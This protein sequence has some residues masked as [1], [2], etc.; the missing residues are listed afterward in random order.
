M[1]VKTTMVLIHAGEGQGLVLNRDGAGRVLINEALK[2]CTPG[3]GSQAAA[4]TAVHSDGASQVAA[5]Q[6]TCPDGSAFAFEDLWTVVDEDTVQVDRQV[7]VIRRGTADGFRFELNVVS[8]F[9]ATHDIEDLQF[10]IPGALYNK[11]DT[12]HDGIDDYLHTFEQSYRD[13]RLPSLS[14]MAFIPATGSYLALTRK[15]VPEFDTAVTTEEILQREFVQRT[16]IG[17]LGLAPANDAWSQV[18][19]VASY[20][21]HEPYSFCLNTRR[22]EWAAYLDSAEGELYTISYQLIF[23]SARSLTDAIWAVT[24]HQM[25]A[26]NAQPTPLILPME[27]LMR[28]RI[29]MSQSYYREWSK[30]ENLNEPAGYMVHF[31]PRT[32]KTLGSLLEYGFAGAQTFLAFVSLKWGHQHGLTEYVR[33]AYRVFDFFVRHCQLDNG[34]VHGIYDVDKRDWV[35][36]WTGILLP[37][38]HTKDE[39]ELRDDLGSQMVDA[40]LPIANR[41]RGIEGN[42]TRS[43]CEA[44][45]P[46]L[47]AYEEERERGVVHEEWLGVGKKFGNFLLNV[48]APDGSFYRGYG[49][50]GR[51]LEEPVEWFGASYTERKSGTN[52]PVQVLAQLYRLTGEQQYRDA[53]VRAGDF[54][55]KEY[56]DSVEYLGGLNDTTHIK[57]VK[58][59]AVGV[60]FAMRSLLRIYDL[61]KTPQYLEGAVK[62]AKVLASWVYLWNV[63]MP[64]ESLLGSNNYKSTGWAVCDVIPAGSYLDDEYMEFIGDALKIARYSGE[65]GLVDVAELVSKGM[66]QALSTPP[67]MLGYAKAGMQCEG[68]MTAY[69][70]SDPEKSAR[71]SGAANKR[72]GD[73]NDTVNGLINAQAIYGYLEMLDKYGT[74][75]FAEIRQQLAAKI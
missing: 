33:R 63:P 50:D 40:L 3:G 46:L 19:M 54:L 27:E 4:Y 12:D 39:N 10:F 38:Q 41:L 67:Q 43:M 21:F 53:A 1:T 14:V 37:F 20:P 45:Y 56:V 69:W 47:L 66:Q 62:A 11:N 9:A 24:T 22:D 52:F 64:P 42:Y 71:F 59:D 25:A 72:K 26:L 51:G 44:V 32:G 60:M 36:W 8:E 13:D 65:H 30:A 34:F 29:E 73:D 35:Y 57:S 70:L 58:I 23:G 74:S 6:I 31:S 55:L 18:R 7:R 15:D 5:G 75:D 68:L 16:D 17:S 2:V 28:Y 49:T 48:Q 61:C